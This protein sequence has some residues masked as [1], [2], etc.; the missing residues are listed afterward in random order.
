[1]TLNVR[2]PDE[3]NELIDDEFIDLIRNIQRAARY[4]ERNLKLNALSSEQRTRRFLYTHKHYLVRCHA[5]M[6]VSATTLPMIRDYAI[7]QLVDSRIAS[8]EV[9]LAS[10]TPR[11]RVLKTSGGHCL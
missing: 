1:L 6:E 4:A 2:R 3:V 11:K 7:A 9:K 8:S 10:T 5:Q